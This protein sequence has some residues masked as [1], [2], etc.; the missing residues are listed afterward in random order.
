MSRFEYVFNNLPNV[1]QYKAAVRRKVID[2]N[3]ASKTTELAR[4]QTIQQAAAAMVAQANQSQQSVS[5]LFRSS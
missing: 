2:A 1:A 4:T 3:Y 5:A